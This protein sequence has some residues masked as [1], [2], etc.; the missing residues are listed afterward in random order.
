MTQFKY[1]ATTRTTKNARLRS[2]HNKNQGIDQ[3]ITVNNVFNNVLVLSLL[4]AS[5]QKAEMILL[6]PMMW[7]LHILLFDTM[8]FASLRIKL[9]ISVFSLFPGFLDFLVF[10]VLLYILDVGIR[11]CIDLHFQSSQHSHL[12]SKL[13]LGLIAVIIVVLVVIIICP[14]RRS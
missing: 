2:H 4:L 12:L 9:S 11:D 7:W 6:V 1:V 14:I 10:V 8:R 3:H 5:M 13:Y